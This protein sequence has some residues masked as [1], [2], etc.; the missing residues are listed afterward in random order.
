MPCQV[1]V[2]IALR[3]GSL[4]D[5]S[6]TL[7]EM[8]PWPGVWAKI[9]LER[10]RAD[11]TARAAKAHPDRD[12]RIRITVYTPSTSSIVLIRKSTHCHRCTH[13]TPIP[14]QTQITKRTQQPPGDPA[15][16]P[17]HCAI[18]VKNSCNSYDYQTLETFPVLKKP[19]LTFLARTVLSEHLCV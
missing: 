8:T 16:R 18:S 14:P 19:S 4:F 6:I 9:I 3:T 10:G 5:A 2:T 1:R 15:L 7:P 11:K 17:R 12:R 13:M